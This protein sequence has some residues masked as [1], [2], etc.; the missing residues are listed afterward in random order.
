MTRGEATAA[1]FTMCSAATRSLF[2]RQRFIV[3]SAFAVGAQVGY[4]FGRFHALGDGDQMQTARERNGVADNC[5][6]V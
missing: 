5:G 2:Q 4:L 6:I 1:Y 3:S